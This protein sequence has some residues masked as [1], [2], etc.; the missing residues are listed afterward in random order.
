M[1]DGEH[2]QDVGEQSQAALLAQHR[3]GPSEQIDGQGQVA[4]RV[5]G[6]TQ[7]PK[8]VRLR[9]VREPDSGQSRRDR[10]A[11]NYRLSQGDRGDASGIIRPFR[12]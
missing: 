3:L 12:R 5:C 4:D 6:V 11:L 7:Q 10:R 8:G 9:I 1:I 2:R